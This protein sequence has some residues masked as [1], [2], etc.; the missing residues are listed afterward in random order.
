[1][2]T[3]EENM[4]Y[5][6]VLSLGQPYEGQ[7]GPRGEGTT[8]T[9]RYESHQ[10]TVFLDRPSVREIEA[11]SNGP[12]RFGFWETPPVLWVIFQVQG[13]EWSDA[14]YTPYLVEP[15]GR[16]LPELETPDTRYLVTMTLADATDGRVVGLRAA[17]MSAGMSRELREAVGRQMDRP[18]IPG[19]FDRM[20]QKIYRQHPGSFSMKD[21]ARRMETL[22]G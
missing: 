11:F 5:G 21:M 22:G 3:S 4:E 6:T 17:T 19:E 7:P 12:V 10:L 13:M 20:I 15:E 14:P 8:Y 16:T 2:H 1:M 18:E 9:F